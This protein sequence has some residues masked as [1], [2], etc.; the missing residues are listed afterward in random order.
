MGFFSRR[1][2]EREEAEDAAPVME[3]GSLIRDGG[4]VSPRRIYNG[5]TDAAKTGAAEMAASWWSRALSAAQVAGDPT[6]TVSHS[7]LAQVGRALIREGEAVYLIEVI[8]GGVV[9]SPASAQWSRG[10]RDPTRWAYWLTVNGPTHS[11]IVRARADQVVHLK[12]AELPSQ[13]WRGVSPLA[14]AS[15]TA[16]RAFMTEQ[17]LADLAASPP[18]EIPTITFPEKLGKVQR[19]NFLDQWVNN[20]IG[21]DRRPLILENTGATGSMKTGL[22]PD[23]ADIENAKDVLSTMAAAC[24]IPVNL[25]AGTD[26]PAG[27]RESYRTF[28]FGSVLPVAEVLT[29]ELRLKLD[30]PDLTLK[31]EELRAADI[32]GR[33]RSYMSLVKAGYPAKQAAEVCGLPEPTAATVTAEAGLAGQQEAEGQPDGG[34][35]AEPQ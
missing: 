7:F 25:V 34:S 29:E 23:A 33:A 10:D 16:R 13:P 18:G 31:F 26:T 20:E 8:D 35:P 24:G 4:F 5:L 14:L 3:M 19:E 21:V 1:V 17:R 11:R 27:V 2:E 12:W 22:A 32:Q 28:L 30:A 9:L 15:Q 6:G